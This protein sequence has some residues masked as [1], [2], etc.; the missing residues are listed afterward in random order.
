MYR[1]LYKWIWLGRC[2]LCG[3]GL[4]VGKRMVVW[5]DV[6]S[7]GWWVQEHQ[8]RLEGLDR[9]GNATFVVDVNVRKN[10]LKKRMIY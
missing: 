2:P 8:L 9:V 1:K 3:E 5:R 7:I 10:A 4:I 6:L